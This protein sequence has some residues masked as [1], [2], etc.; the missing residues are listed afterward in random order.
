VS[1]ADKLWLKFQGSGTVTYPELV[2]LMGHNGF[3]EYKAAGSSGRK[4][5]NKDGLQFAI[6]EPH[7]EKTLKTYQKVG[8]RKFIKKYLES[9]K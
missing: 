3:Q 6:H 5:E 7:P 8:A 2:R 1:R 9:T 4:F